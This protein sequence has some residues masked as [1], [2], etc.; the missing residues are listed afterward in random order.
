MGLDL[1]YCQCYGAEQGGD[2]TQIMG[3]VRY[4]VV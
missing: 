1:T 2:D 4:G 3:G